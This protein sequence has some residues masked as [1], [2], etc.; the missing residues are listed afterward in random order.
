MSCFP[1]GWQ[2]YSS[3]CMPLLKQE[4]GAGDGLSVTGAELLCW[5]FMTYSLVIC[6][7]FTI[8]N[9][10]SCLVS[11]RLQVPHILKE[12]FESVRIN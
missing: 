3:W 4:T 7:M 1:P 10:L 8:V 6:P 9:C 12:G 5:S 2:H 11:C